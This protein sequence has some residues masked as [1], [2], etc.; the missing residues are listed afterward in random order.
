MNANNIGR[1]EIQDEGAIAISSALAR[2]PSLQKLGIG[3]IYLHA[4]LIK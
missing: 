4:I 1:C 2:H 3:N